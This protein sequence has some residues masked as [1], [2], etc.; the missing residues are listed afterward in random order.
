M[1]QCPC[2]WALGETIADFRNSQ[3]KY[4]LSEKGM[5][6]KSDDLNRPASFLAVVGRRGENS[7]TCGFGVWP[8]TYKA[9]LG[10][11]T[12]PTFEI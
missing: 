10:G 9:A 1:S 3:G 4:K 8:L 6:S 5:C 12:C 2:A 7:H 11:L